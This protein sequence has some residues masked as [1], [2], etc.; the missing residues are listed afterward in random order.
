VPVEQRLFDDRFES[1]IG[2]YPG[3]RVVS[4]VLLLQFKRGTVPDIIANVLFVDQNLVD[5]AGGP[6]APQIRENAPLIEAIRDFSLGFAI[7][8]K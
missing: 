5:S 1:S 2:A 6:C 3:L 8:D 7:L 4:L